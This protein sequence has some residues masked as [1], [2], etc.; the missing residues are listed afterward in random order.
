[1]TED[2]FSASAAQEGTFDHWD[3]RNVARLVGFLASDEAADVNGQF[4]VVFGGNIWAMGGFQPI[5]EVHRDAMWTIEELAAAKG[6]L[7]KNGPS[8]IPPFAVQG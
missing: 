3:P 8:Q 7:F 2:V 4:F 6:D 1:M 5:G